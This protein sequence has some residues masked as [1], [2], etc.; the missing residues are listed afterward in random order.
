MKYLIFILSIFFVL[1]TFSYPKNPD[2]NKSPGDLC[3]VSDKDFKEYRYPEHIVYCERNVTSQ[4]KQKIY[5]SYNIP[6]N[7]RKEYTIDHI[8]PL[9]IGGSNSD[10]N[11]W[12][13]HKAVKATRPHLEDEVYNDLRTARKTQQEVIDLILK[14][15]FKTEPQDVEE[16]H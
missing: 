15:K 9:S 10:L 4:R 3:T 12:P 8:I 5:D 16:N 1:T 13:E 7:E 6:K 11:L 14:E 2:V